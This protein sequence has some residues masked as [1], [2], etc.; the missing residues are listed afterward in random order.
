MS[1]LERAADH[2]RE[3]HRHA[4]GLPL[5]PCGDKAAGVFEDLRG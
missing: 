3:Q 4:L 1:R 2:W 5:V